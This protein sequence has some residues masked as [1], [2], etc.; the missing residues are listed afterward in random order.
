MAAG[1][2]RRLRPLTERYAKPVLPIGG[3]PVIAGILRDLQAAGIGRI[4]VVT[5]HLAEQVERLLDRFPHELR[6]VRQT[7]ALGGADAVRH[8][9]L[10]PPYVVVGADTVFSPGDVARFVARAP[11]YD[12]AVA[13]RPRPNAPVQNRVRVEDGLVTR[14]ADDD[15]DNT[16]TGAPLWF[17]GPTA[18]AQL[19]GLP[20]PP[21]EL[22]VALQR[23]HD[24]GHRIG[25][26][27]IGP[28]RD[29]TDPEDVIRENF[30]YLRGL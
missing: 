1:E 19:A 13:V 10:D 3:R 15:P 8:A 29:L 12:D 28:T 14:F 18:H 7:Q 26:I 22:S 30:G 25:G 16:T 11:A 6:F 2:G 17:V 9:A 21:Y 4:T 20:G 5:G 27:R 24:E 23:S